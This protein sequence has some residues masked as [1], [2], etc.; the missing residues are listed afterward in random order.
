VTPTDGV[1]KRLNLISQKLSMQLDRDRYTAAVAGGKNDALAFTL[2]NQR[3][4]SPHTTHVTLTGLAAGSY[5]VSVGGVAAGDL[6][7]TAGSPAVLALSVGTEPTYAVQIGTTCPVVAGTGGAAGTGSGGASGGTP[8]ATGGTAA[9]GGSPGAAG[10]PVT[11]GAPPTSGACSCEQ[12]A[13][14]GTIGWLGCVALLW[15]LGRLRRRSRR[16]AG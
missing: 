2:Q 1:F 13:R 3:P 12:T 9:T 10:A 14:P 6:T 5:P 16:R 8:G 15:G 11:G 7:A 4:G